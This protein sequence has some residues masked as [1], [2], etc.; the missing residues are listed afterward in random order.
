MRGADFGALRSACSGHLCFPLAE[1]GEAAPGI[2]PAN[3]ALPPPRFAVLVK[4]GDLP[5]PR[6]LVCGME[7]LAAS[8]QGL[9]DGNKNERLPNAPQTEAGR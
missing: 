3:L 6:P 4:S 7:T 8:L 2:P 1:P 5:E 9:F